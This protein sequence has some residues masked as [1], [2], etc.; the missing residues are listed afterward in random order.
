[1]IP[2]NGKLYIREWLLYALVHIAYHL[3]SAYAQMRFP[4]MKAKITPLI[5]ET[6]KPESRRSV[7]GHLN[8]NPTNKQSRI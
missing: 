4:K 6:Y 2:I 7:F 1:M 5:T 3:Y 8:L